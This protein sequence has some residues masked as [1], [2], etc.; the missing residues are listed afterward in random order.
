[1]ALSQTAI[2]RW[3]LVHKWTSIVATGFLL[4]LCITG[5]PLIFHHEIDE[6]TRAPQIEEV[7]PAQRSFR[8]D[9]MVRRAHAEVPRGWK[10]MFITW[11]D[12]NPLINVILVPSMKAGEGEAKILPFDARTGERLN[13]PPANEGVMYF[14]LD[15]HASLLMGLP[16]TLFLGL[17]GLVFVVAIIS[18]VVVYAPFMRRLAFG[19]VRKD[20]S[21]RIKWLDTH[22][23]TGI[24]TLG[25]VSVVGVTGLLL[26]LSTPIQML[27]R[28]DQMAE[29]GAPYKGLP[30]VENPVPVD[31]ALATVKAQVPDADISFISWPGSPFSTPHHYMVA[32]K[33]DTPLTE[34]LV[35]GAMVDAETGKLTNVA[36][37]PWYVNMLFLSVP[38]HFG[39]Y[40]GMPLKIIWALLDIAAI[41]V[42]GSGL[43]LWL[44]RRV[45]ADKRAADIHAVHAARRQLR[46]EVAQ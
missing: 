39:D 37:P 27:W 19:T 46:S 16:G 4:L 30:A 14:I 40:G 26:T 34:R 38:L 41:V 45:P 28:M 29:L 5:L 20:R 33:G 10:T 11:D 25:W 12:D 17:I 43:Y 42:L 18:G 3:Y 1:M 32:M 31:A 21:K 9:D 35:K 44:G 13:A 23:M 24:V 2:R 7:A 6:L 8:L 15:L 36:T 22:N